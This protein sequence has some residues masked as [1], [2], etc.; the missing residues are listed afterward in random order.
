MAIAI[1]ALLDDAIID[2]ENIF[3]CLREKIRKPRAERE[4]TI[5]LV[6][7][8]SVE[9]RSSITIATLIIIESF[10]PLIF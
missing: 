5:T 10:V 4:S 7:D 9:I 8:A 3:K 1:G 6:R 2:V